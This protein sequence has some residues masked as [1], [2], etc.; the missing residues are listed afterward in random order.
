MKINRLFYLLLV[1]MAACNQQPVEEKP[2]P[3]FF[4]D[5]KPEGW[6]KAQ[7]QF[8]ITEGFV[9][10]LDQ[11]VPELILQDDIYGKDRMTKMVKLKDVGA[12]TD[13]NG[14]WQVQFLWWNS[15]TQSNWWDGYIRNA[16]LTQ[17]P[18]ALEKVKTYVDAKLATQDE[19]GYIGVYA[20][21]L[22]YKHTTENG[23][24]W[25]QS[26]LFRGLLAYYEY[27]K[28]QRVLTTIEKAVGLTMKQYPIHASQPFNIE[29]PYAGVGHGLT[30][31]D[32]LHRLFE[33][34]DDTTY[35]AY[36]L[37]LYEDYDQYPLSEVDIQT[38]NLLDTAYRFQGHGVHTYEH[39][40]ALILAS[41]QSKNPTYKQALAAYLSKLETVITPSGA[42]IGDEWIF[43][44]HANADQTGYEYCSLQELIDSYS[45]L[46]ATT[47][48]AIW[49]DKMEHLLFNAAQGARAVD[50]KSIA[51][52]KTDNSYFMQG[53]LEKE[54]IGKDNHNRF[55]YSPVHK[56]VA[57]CCVPNAGRIYP[58]YIKS[59]WSTSAKG[60]QLNLFGA[61]TLNTTI[62]GQKVQIEQIT[63]YP[64]EHTIRLKVSIDAPQAFQIAIRKPSW[65][66]NYSLKSDAKSSES[67]GYI[68]LEKTW[69]NGDEITIE[70][71]A[72]PQLHTF[73][74]NEQYISHG[75]LVY[76][77]PIVGEKQVKKSYP[78]G[79]FEDV[80]FTSTASAASKWRIQTTEQQLTTSTTPN[81]NNWQ[82]LK[83]SLNLIDTLGQTQKVN[84]VPMGGQVLRQVTFPTVLLNESI[85]NQ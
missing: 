76:A 4:G 44:K 9:G 84:L 10:N 42:P 2:T 13:D 20:P 70:F 53:A 48:N 45:L 24:L 63:N 35:S 61:S 85:E 38:K 62:N 11:L 7:M 51:Y 73:Q 34:T 64:F 46:L 74:T 55:K 18:K 14:D 15:E 23:E 71:E 80:Y 28:E 1:V 27:S 3:L 78:F 26:S 57:V 25:A 75:P 39:L 49:A 81:T 67:S 79:G 5:I 30:F 72:T 8:D 52:C 58:Y 82:Q 31:V 56:E 66:E 40:R 65:A 68:F 22:R 29:K 12:I 19:D 33:L 50:G 21:D 16:I 43:G 41:E 47:G 36:A 83:L 32:V 17:E 37:F 54:N 77:M 69:K 60:L 6:M 59:M